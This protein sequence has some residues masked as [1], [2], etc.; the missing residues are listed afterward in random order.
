[1]IYITQFIYIKAGQ[2]AVF[3]EFESYAIPIISNYGGKLELRI[4]TPKDV[5]V[6]GTMETPDEIHLVSFPSEENFRAFLKDE[7]RKKYVH[8]KEQS[9]EKVTMLKGI[10]IG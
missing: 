6:E 2:E 4:R 9:I 8:L 7:E 5:R 1:M 10:N 3:N